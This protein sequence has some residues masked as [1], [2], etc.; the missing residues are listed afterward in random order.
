ME[1]F[2]YSSGYEGGDC[3]A[4]LITVSACRPGV[5]VQLSGFILQCGA[6]SRSSEGPNDT[7]AKGQDALG[8][9]CISRWGTELVLGDERPCFATAR[10]SVM[11]KNYIVRIWLTNALENAC[12]DLSFTDLRPSKPASNR[13][14]VAALTDTL[15]QPS[16]HAIQQPNCVWHH[17]HPLPN[18]RST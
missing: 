7:E 10:T 6:L 14:L 13:R 18:S 16:L 8:F 17:Y 15:Q 11:I 5:C 3:G 2:V 1:T 12:N 9:L 4:H